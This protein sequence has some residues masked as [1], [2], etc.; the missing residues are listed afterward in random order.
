MSA[1]IILCARSFH[2]MPKIPLRDYKL[3]LIWFYI[4]SVCVLVNVCTAKE[5]LLRWA[6]STTGGNNNTIEAE[7]EIT[8]EAESKRN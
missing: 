2:H 1:L 3:F 8:M 5:M 4:S 6:Y 7:Q